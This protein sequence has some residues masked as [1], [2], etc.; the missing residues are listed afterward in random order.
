VEEESA[1]RDLTTYLS[2]DE[3]EAWI[4]HIVIPALESAYGPNILH[5]LPHSFAEVKYKSSIGMEYGDR[6][7]RNFVGGSHMDITQRLPQHI[8]EP[9]WQK[10]Q[11][12]C[13]E[14]RYTI[15][16]GG[17]ETQLKV[18]KDPLLV[19]A[20]HEL[21]LVTARDTEPKTDCLQSWAEHFNC[22]SGYKRIQ[23]E[24]YFFAG[25][26]AAGTMTVELKESKFAPF[27][28]WHCIC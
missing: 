14:Y 18:F 13:S 16:R 21:K 4:D 5:H 23:K 19:I 27:R 10:V 6:N 2:D 15:T 22:P 1:F 17:D 28:G 11:Q 8:L 24:G 7:S 26:K 9:F 20:G 25:T 12:L 3:Q